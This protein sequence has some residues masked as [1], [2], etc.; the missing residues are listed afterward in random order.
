MSTRDNDRTDPKTAQKEPQAQERRAQGPDPATITRAQELRDEGLTLKQIK[1]RLTSEGHSAPS[2]QHLS[3]LTTPAAKSP[4]VNKG[5]GKGR[6]LSLLVI[7]RA[8]QLR[9][10]GLTLKQVSQALAL[11]GYT[12]APSPSALSARTTPAQEN[13]GHRPA[14]PQEQAER[15]KARHARAVEAKREKISH[16]RANESPADRAERLAW[17][18]LEY[19]MRRGAQAAY[20]ARP[21]VKARRPKTRRLKEARVRADQL[22]LEES[23]PRQDTPH[24][25]TPRQDT[26]HQ[27][28]PHRDN[29][30]SATDK[31]PLYPIPM[32]HARARLAQA[33]A[34]AELSTCTRRK[35]GALIIDPITRAVISDGYNGPPRKGGAL[36]SE[37]GDTCTRDTEHITSG[38]N[39]ERGCYHAEANAIFNAAR[40]G[41]RTEGAVILTTAAPCLACARAIYHAGLVAVMTPSQ[42][43]PDT[44]GLA[45][46]SRFGLPHFILYAVKDSGK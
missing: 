39:L 26:P 35:V 22:T 2:T 21:E 25:D 32:R 14:P 8:Q 19:E 45:F 20:R 27:D 15:T 17:N 24:Q 6:P 7:E 4:R 16:E 38:T 3:R 40:R 30:E 41:A 12:P 11:E 13:R 34:L 46:L 44:E 23:T 18:A 29:T 36:C 33:L 9:D 37:E 28:T 31:A 1:A 43:Y 5:G 42:S 10:E